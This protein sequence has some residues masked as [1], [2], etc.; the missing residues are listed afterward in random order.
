MMNPERHALRFV[1]KSDA[2]AGPD[3][4]A[5]PYSQKEE[6]WGCCGGAGSPNAHT[7]LEGLAP[8]LLARS[9]SF[10]NGLKPQWR[11]EAA[12]GRAMIEASAT[13]LGLVSAGVFVAHALDAY[14]S[15]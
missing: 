9:K 15:N 13:I 10:P 6:S 2:V 4:S 12:R 7:T 3:I 5:K 11:A 1:P 14:F 8:L